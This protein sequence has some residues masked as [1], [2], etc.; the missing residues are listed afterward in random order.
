MLGEGVLD[1]ERPEH[2][3]IAMGLAGIFASRLAKDH[4]AF[5]FPNRDSMEGA[6]IGFP[7]ALIVLAPLGAIIDSLSQAKL[8]RL[9]QSD[10]RHPHVPGAG[11]VLAHPGRSTATDPRGLRAAV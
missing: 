2:Q 7:E 3:A 11:E 4:N 1:L 6:A 8:D 9:E 10:H 5:W